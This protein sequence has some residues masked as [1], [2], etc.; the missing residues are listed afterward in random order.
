YTT[1]RSAI[2]WLLL[3]LCWLAT[4][5]VVHGATIGAT[6]NLSTTRDRFSATLLTSG[7]VLVVGGIGPSGTLSSAERYDPATG[8]W[9]AAASASALRSYHP[10]TLLPSGKVFVVG[11]FDGSNALSS[12]E[13]YDPTTNTWAAAASMSTARFGLSATL[14]RS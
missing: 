1:R 10:A 12:A 14:L 6:G 7:Q 11:G 8:T 4:V 3:L 5:A 2:H 13:I 9:S